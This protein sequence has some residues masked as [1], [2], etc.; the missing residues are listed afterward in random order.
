M[1]LTAPTVL[2]KFVVKDVLGMYTV[3]RQELQKGIRHV[4]QTQFSSNYC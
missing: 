1:L 4:L 2:W 3:Q